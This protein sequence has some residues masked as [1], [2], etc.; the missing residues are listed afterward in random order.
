MSAV[1]HVRLSHPP[2]IPWGTK[3][4]KRAKHICSYEKMEKG[5]SSEHGSESTRVVY[6]CFRVEDYFPPAVSMRHHCRLLLS[7][8]VMASNW[9]NYDNVLFLRERQ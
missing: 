5:N 6:Y 7:G 8:K 2:P 1:K 3:C 9:A 4:S